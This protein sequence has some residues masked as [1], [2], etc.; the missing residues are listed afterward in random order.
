MSRLLTQNPIALR[1]LMSETVFRS[2]VEN[3]LA[4]KMSIDSIKN[5]LPLSDNIEPDFLFWGSNERNILFLT[6]NLE[7]DY[8]SID[9]EDAF[10]KTLAALNLSLN[11]VAVFNRRK[12]DESTDRICEVLNPKICIFCEGENESNKAN[13]NKISTVEGVAC[14]YTFSFEEMLTDT[15]KKRAFWNA[16]KG[17]TIV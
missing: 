8:F 4:E 16:I 2:A 6:Q 11:D 7:E 9:A 12:V 14:L 1:F 15:N 3:R 17:I 13:F 10:L 5:D